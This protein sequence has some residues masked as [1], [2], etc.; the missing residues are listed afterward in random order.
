MGRCKDRRACGQNSWYVSLTS[1]L[2]LTFTVLSQ[3]SSQI[4]AVAPDRYVKRFIDFVESVV[5]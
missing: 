3:D 1:P 4:S 2:A 5:V